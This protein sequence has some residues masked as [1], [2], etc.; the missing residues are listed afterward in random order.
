MPIPTAV[1]RGQFRE[2]LKPLCS[3]LGVN[4]VNIFA[5]GVRL[6]ADSITFNL[7]ALAAAEPAGERAAPAKAFKRSL[8]EGCPP[9][10]HDPDAKPIVVGEDEWSQWAYAVKVEVI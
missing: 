6:D 4:D 3:L 8:P 2:A 5:D 10:P 7:A 1:T 9:H